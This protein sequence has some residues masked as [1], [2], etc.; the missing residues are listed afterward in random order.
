MVP[1]PI[2][3]C[4]MI[5]CMPKMKLALFVFGFF[6]LEA[7]AVNAQANEPILLIAVIESLEK[8]HGVKFLYDVD[9]VKGVRVRLGKLPDGFNDKLERLTSLTAFKFTGADDGTVW[10]L[11]EVPGKNLRISGT[12][13]DADR[14]EPIPGATLRTNPGKTGT[15]TDASGKY[16]LYVNIHEESE[17]MISSVGF[18][19]QKYPIEFFNGNTAPT[20]SLKINVTVLNEVVVTAYMASGIDYLFR[21][22]SIEIRPDAMAMLPGETDTDILMALDALPGV[23]TPD[24][25]AGNLLIRGSSPDQT[26]ITVD[27]IPIYHKGHYFGTIS[28]YNPAMID[29]VRVFRSAY[30]AS[31]GGRVGG[32]IEIN[33]KSTVADSSRFGV[34]IST[35]YTSAF[36]EIPL[37]KNKVSMMMAVRNSL[38]SG[39]ISPKLNAINEFIYRESE[40]HQTENDPNFHLRQREYHF[41]DV[42]AKFS[43]RL[44]E[45]NVVSLSLLAID[46]AIE[47]A[48]DDI[49]DDAINYDDMSLRNLGYNLQWNKAWSSKFS[50]QISGT[51]SSYIQTYTSRSVQ[52]PNTLTEDNYFENTLTDQSIKFNSEFALSKNSGLNFGYDLQR[53]RQMYDDISMTEEINQTAAS[54][55]HALY[56][57]Y[58][59]TKPDRYYLAAG[60]RG[61]HYSRIADSRVEPRLMFNYFL[62]DTWAL[63]SSFGIFHQYVNQVSGVAIE[64]V[65]GIENLLWQL[66]DG[67]NIP[68]V[69]SNQFMLGAMYHSKSWLLDVEFYKNRID[70]LILNDIISFSDTYLHGESNTIGMDVLLR[71]EWKKV[72]SWI[73]YTLSHTRTQF[74]EIQSDAFDYVF[75]QRHVLDFVIGYNV[76]QWKFSLGWKYRSGLP[77]LPA[78]RTK[79]LHGPPSAG[80]PPPPP[81]PPGGGPP[82][83]A[84]GS[85]EMYPDRFPAY[86]QVDLALARSFPK[87]N[88]GW[89]GSLG[90][91]LL[92]LFDRENLVEQIPRPTPQGMFIANKYAIGFAP[93]LVLNIRW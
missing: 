52:S 63:K 88:K 2:K 15:V 92:N 22:N 77:S 12:L 90:V 64:S 91:S 61:N 37:V 10:V 50:T 54:N 58:H 86:S 70:D 42:N 26:L 71:K 51:Q 62:S 13:L 40:V 68:I 89:N 85:P 20:L 67:D 21:D 11:P 9:L 49:Q 30:P 60:V 75:D 53:Q 55:L 36:A 31:K 78:I 7:P 47:I 14:N 48:I 35:T 83:L 72:S 65:G 33:T 82:P 45:K 29:H 84:P 6:Y 32:V 76:E 41:W 23:N 19:E 69:R 44:N 24:S 38:P 28:P 1:F 80:T 59:F 87:Q 18:M 27:N 43:A 4:R 79:Y 5:S 81:P 73:S 34:G 8:E 66:A 56:V 93:N 25:K 74:D 17:L 3:P 46:N 57:N 16:V 39:W